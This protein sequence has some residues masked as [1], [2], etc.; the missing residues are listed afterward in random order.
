MRSWTPFSC[1]S[2][3]YA[4]R[5]KGSLQRSFEPLCKPSVFRLFYWPRGVSGVGFLSPGQHGHV[6]GDAS[7]PRLGPLGV[8]DLVQDG[9]PV[10]LVE[11]GEEPT[12]L[13]VLLQLP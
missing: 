9:V 11:L 10:P 2:T 8:L 4:S 6:F 13:F 3:T 1:R 7:R 5:C 12:S